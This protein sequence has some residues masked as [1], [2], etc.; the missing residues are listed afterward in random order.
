MLEEKSKQWTWT[1]LT[2]SS[3][4]LHPPIFTKD[5]NYFFSVVGSSIKIH[6]T[7]SGKVI[8]TLPGS[9]DQGHSD[10]ITAAIL[11]TQNAFQLITASLDGTI[12]I[13]DFLDGVL[14]YTLNLEQPIY[15]MC[16]HEKITDHIFVSAAKPKANRRTDGASETRAQN[17]DESCIVL[18]V[19]LKPKDRNNPGIKIHKSSSVTPVGKTRATSGLAVSASGGWLIAIAGHKAYVANTSS[20]KAGFTKYVSPDP[21]TCLSVHPTEDYFA[22]GDHKGVVRLWYCLNQSIPK[23]VGVEKRSQTSTFHWHAHAVSSVAFSTN[24]AYLLSGGE[25]SVLVIWQLHSGKKEF[26][27]RVG[28][29][30]NNIVVSRPH[31]AEEEYLLSLADAS[32]AFI[33]SATLKLSRVFSRIKLDPALPNH[34]ASSSSRISLAVHAAS[35]TLILPSS[36]PSSLQTYSPSSS[37][38]IAELEVSPSN[39]VSRTDDRALE[40]SRVEHVVISASG[41]WM[42]TIDRREGDGTFRGEVYLKFWWWDKKAA[43]WILNT[44]IDQPHGSYRVTSLSFNPLGDSQLIQLVTTGE[45]GNV[46]TWRIRSTKD[47]KGG[48]EVSWMSRSTFTFRRETPKHTSWSPDGSLLAVSYSASVAMYDPTTNVLQHNFCCSE[49]PEVSSAHFVGPSGRNLVVMGKVSLVVWDIVTQSVRWHYSNPALIQSVVVHPT[50]ES[51]AIFSPIISNS[52]KCEVNVFRVQSSTP[53]LTQTLPF[54]LLSVAWYPTSPLPSSGPHVTKSSFSIVG[55]THSYNVVHFGEEISHAAELGASAN[56]LS[57]GASVTKRSLFQEMFGVPALAE[58]SDQNTNVAS[59][60]NDV[61]LPWRGSETG[62]IFDGPSYLMPPM[63]TLFDSLISGFLKIRLDNEEEQQPPKGPYDID[64]EMQVD[65][66]SNGDEAFAVRLTEVARENVL[67]TF[68][69]FFMEMTGSAEYAFQANKASN[70]TKPV[71][72][73]TPQPRRP[74]ARPPVAQ[75]VATPNP[76]TPNQ[77]PTTSL[78]AKAGKKRS[79]HSL[80]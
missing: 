16:A 14:L 1:S 69:P 25:E 51:F 68:V 36:H 47:K 29:P 45:D 8:S 26:V 49:V 77:T 17:Q 67:Q 21:L 22:T 10:I 33:S 24:G 59:S 61:T 73:S 32:Y 64:S 18:K 62:K 5:G 27:P 46:K 71:V 37:I 80:G 70:P 75:K 12:K 19:S 78:P 41:E 42:A 63:E 43:F 31:A 23:V 53:W 40:P 57:K 52:P 48:S 65:S 66:P 38:L 35:D 50:H 72:A 28:S 20:L 15:H 7:V 4:S 34:T 54:K 56:A 30:I 6:S 55:I 79:R 60:T 74:L 3:T 13:W 9:Q 39:R 58:I 2:D 44:R 11:S 76:P